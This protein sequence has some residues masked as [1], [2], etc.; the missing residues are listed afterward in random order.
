MTESFFA[1]IKGDELNHEWY[2]SQPAARFATDDYLTNFYNPVHRH[3][4]LGYL[5]P[6][7]F[8]LR[9]RVNQMAA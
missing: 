4:T 7:E 5:S 3:S 1:T 2:P 6:D 9:A 8:E